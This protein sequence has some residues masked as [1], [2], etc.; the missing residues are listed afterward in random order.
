M[1]SIITFLFT[2]LPML[3][4]PYNSNSKKSGKHT[5]TN[6]NKLSKPKV[7]SSYS[8]NIINVKLLG[9]KGDGINDETKA[10]KSALLKAKKTGSIVYYPAGTYLQGP[11]I[12]N[13]NNI[14]IKGEKGTK[15]IRN[16]IRGWA[17]SGKIN[18]SKIEG[19][20]IDC[21]KSPIEGGIRI[22]GKNNVLSNIRILNGDAGSIC[23]SSRLSNTDVPI[24]TLNNVVIDCYVSGQKKYHDVGGLSPFIAGDLATKTTF[25]RCTAV[26]CAGVNIDYFDSDNAPKT[27]FDQCTAIKSGKM[28]QSTAFWSEGEQSTTDH[29]VEWRNCKAVNFAIAFGSSERAKPLLRNCR[30][31]N[32][33]KAYNHSNGDFMPTIDGL[34]CVKCG[35]GIENTD[36]EAI[37]STTGGITLRNVVTTES[38]AKQSFVNFA[39]SKYTDDPVRIGFGC[40]FDRIVRISYGG[41]GS[42]KIFMNDCKLINTSL[43]YYNAQDV[44]MEVKRVLFDK[45]SKVVGARISKGSKIDECRFIGSS[46]RKTNSQ[47]STAIT[48][49]LDNFNLIVERSLFKN[50]KHPVDPNTVYKGRVTKNYTD[51]TIKIEQFNQ[52][53]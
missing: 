35:H 16:N 22:A 8:D 2:A 48:Q 50:W 3:C 44:R 28:S 49:L 24:Q 45:G 19:L 33:T 38:I 15:I 17:F 46:N 47:D 39:N 42:R 7:E 31:E 6:V 26:N 14:K 21:N 12:I 32:C 9:A 11:I 1:L 43:M 4:S 53:N 5:E 41:T 29:R 18:F 34:L 37:I 52:L 40:V 27:L 10:I 36:T 23:I 20:T 25:R 51:F 13:G 30:A